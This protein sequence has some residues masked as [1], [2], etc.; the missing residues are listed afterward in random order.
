MVSFKA[1]ILGEY[2]YQKDFAMEKQIHL[3]FTEQRNPLQ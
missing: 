2:Y 1:H 3:K